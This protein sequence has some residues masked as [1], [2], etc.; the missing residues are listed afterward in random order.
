MN[1]VTLLYLLG[2]RPNSTRVWNFINHFRQRSCAVRNRVALR[3]V[4]TRE[5]SW[6]H[7]DPV[8]GEPGWAAPATGGFAQCCESCG[9]QPDCAAWT[10]RRGNCTLLASVDSDGEYVCPR[11]DAGESADSCSSGDR[12]AYE[13]WTTLPQLFKQAGYL[14]LG[15][16][17][18]FHDGCGN[19][20]GAPGDANHP[21]GAGKP[22]MA[23]AALS[24]SGGG[25]GDAADEGWSAVQFPDIAAYEARWGR[26]DNPYGAAPGTFLAPI[27]NGACAKDGS[28]NS[29]DFCTPAG[30]GADGA[31]A[32]EPLCDFVTYNDAVVKLR[33]AAENRRQHAQPFFM[34]LGVRRPHLNWRAPAAYADLYPHE[35]TALPDQRTLDPSI[36]SV[37]YSVFP[38]DAPTDAAEAG[39]SGGNFVTRPNASGSDDELRAL[40]RHYYGTSTTHLPFSA[41]RMR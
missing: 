40:R 8:A 19:L 34:A 23:D 24:W 35:E 41:A 11:E 7:T 13:T 16:G 1:P 14:S 6:V 30:A 15:V 5:G 3:G 28:S 21:A 17:K 27:D 39:P 25:D 33:Y 32:A 9:A 26:F 18:F 31:G 4:R 2:R 12:G 22:P 37:A 10:Y 38:M 36:D 20:G 29:S